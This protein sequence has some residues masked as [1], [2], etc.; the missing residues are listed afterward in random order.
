MASRTEFKEDAVKLAIGILQSAKEPEHLLKHV[1]Y[2]S[3]T[4]KSELQQQG[5]K[6][7]LAHPQLQPLIEERFAITWPSLEQM[8]AMPR[9]SLGFC[10]QQRQ[11]YL[12]I[13][14]LQIPLPTTDNEEDYVMYRCTICHDLHHLVLG[15]PIS[16]AGEAADSAYSSITKKM[17]LHVGLLATWLTHGL[18]EPEEHRM[19]WEGICFGARIGL[20]GP[21]L[22]AYRWEEGWERPLEEWRAE[23]GLLPLL[24]HSPFQDEVHR[25]E[26]LPS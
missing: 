26:A 14:Q 11:R 10:M 25:W 23:L 18:I 6:Q 22:D 16:V 13:N 9:G 5:I 19:I 21:L 4:N 12:G 20:D 17:P 8:G 7:L 1:K 2:L 24:E 3:I 15:L